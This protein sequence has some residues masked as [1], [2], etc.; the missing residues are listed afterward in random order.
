MMQPQATSPEG[1]AHEAQAVLAGGVSASMRLHPYLDRP[2]YLSKGKGAVVADLEG[3]RYIDFNMS[4]G[5]TILGHGNEATKQA[6]AHGLEL[7]TITAA[8]TPYHEKLARSLTEIIPSAERVR[9]ASTGTE[10]TS[11]AI[12]LA[13]HITGRTKLLKFDAHFHGLAEMFLYKSVDGEVVPSSSGVPEDGAEDV[14]MVPF[15]DPDAFDA[16]LD[17]NRGEIAAIIIEPVHYNVGCIPPEP[18]FLEYLRERTHDQGIILIFDE[19]LSGFRMDLGGA[20]TYYG[21]EPD[22]STWAKALGNGMPISALTGRADIM[23][24]LAPNGPVAH[25][26]TYSGHLLCVLASL[27]TLEQL[28]QPGIYEQLLETSETFYC[29][30][31]S[32]FDRH[33]LPVVVQGLGARFG[34]YFGREGRVT[35]LAD[36][37]NHDHELNRKFVLGCF[38]R[39]I[40]FHAYNRQGPPG[41]NGFSLAHTPEHFAETLNVINDVAAEMANGKGLDA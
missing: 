34:M 29:D 12:R 30:I 18:G 7:G 40:Y 27:A 1:L 2:F 36:T 23:E 25:S 15:N 26:G 37:L 3:K 13:R 8:E 17:R 14:V 32:I 16:A 28:R 21:V 5:A 9:F 6:I 38:K 10:V 24:E 39:G 41:H 35:K 11:V 31:Q 33:G 22:L 19:V 20:Q 4:N